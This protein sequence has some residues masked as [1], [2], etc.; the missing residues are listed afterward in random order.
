[1]LL[2]HDST[3][4][5]SHAVFALEISSR[6]ENKDRIGAV[7]VAFQVADLQVGLIHVQEHLQAGQSI[8]KPLLGDARLVL[9]SAPDMR[10]KKVVLKWW[11]QNPRH[12][13]TLAFT[14]SQTASGADPACTPDANARSEYHHNKATAVDNDEDG[15]KRVVDDFFAAI[16]EEQE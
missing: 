1:M 6:G 8:H 9:P 13:R 2:G 16:I 11:H 5:L 4:Q 15:A 7:D 14:V 12:R 3:A 10:E